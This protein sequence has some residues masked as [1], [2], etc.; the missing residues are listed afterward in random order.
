MSTTGTPAGATD[1]R[2]GVPR[3][4]GGGDIRSMVI[5]MA[6]I[7]GIVV[8]VVWVVPRPNAIEQPAA[9]VANAAEGAR[10]RLSFEPPVPQGLEGWTP[11]SAEVTRSTDDVT[12]WHVGYVSAQ[13]SPLAL[14]V[15]RDATARWQ[16]AYTSNGVEDGTQE[17]GGL[18]WQRFRQDDRSRYSLVREQDG[19][20]VLVAGDADFDE[21]AELVTATLDGWTA[22]GVEWGE[23]AG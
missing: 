21:L 12:T 20:T 17:V 14:E 9:D 22:A 15:A 4:R 11:T 16:G 18:E 19:L 13:G 3:R 1:P 8:A 7:L 23:P 10:S 5:S 2:Q 6:V